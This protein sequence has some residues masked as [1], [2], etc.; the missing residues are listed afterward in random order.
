MTFSLTRERER[1]PERRFSFDWSQKRDYHSSMLDIRTQS[2]ID[3]TKQMTYKTSQVD[4]H[5]TTNER[6]KRD[7]THSLSL[8]IY[9]SFL[10]QILKTSH[11]ILN[12]EGDQSWQNIILFS[13]VFKRMSGGLVAEKQVSNLSV[14]L[15]I[16]CC[17]EQE[18]ISFLFF[19]FSFSNK[20]EGQRFLPWVKERII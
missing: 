9:L 15:R 19:F 6:E 8:Y 3:G 16:K 4:F 13:L 7:P 14:P 17:L 5:F 12:S 11:E 10:P 2:S 1:D 18:K 20:K